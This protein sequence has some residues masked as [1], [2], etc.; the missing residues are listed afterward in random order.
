[1]AARFPFPGSGGHDIRVA[2]NV[3]KASNDALHVL[4]RQQL[5]RNFSG[6]PLPMTET[7][8]KKEQ[9]PFEKR[10]EEIE[11]LLES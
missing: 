9:V 1:V 4:K 11:E 2:Q 6:E 8:P 7:V 5:A 10:D 3:G